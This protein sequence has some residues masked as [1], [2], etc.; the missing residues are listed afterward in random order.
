ARRRPR[1]RRRRSAPTIRRAQRR[2]S[3]PWLPG[4]SC[5]HLFGVEP[6]LERVHAD[7]AVAGEKA[8]VLAAALLQVGF[9]DGFDRA[10]NR[11]AAERGAG[12][13]AQRRIILGA[14][15]ERDLVPLLALL[16]D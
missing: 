11:V 2:P 6:G 15:A 4:C 9:D 14:A 8:F 5:R 12:A 1:S 3:P 13:V 10:G 7:P 16:V